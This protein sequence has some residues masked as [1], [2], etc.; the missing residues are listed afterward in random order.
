M[1]FY[2]AEEDVSSII[3]QEKVKGLEN[4][5]L[6]IIGASNR[7]ISLLHLQKE[8]FLLWNFHPYM[9]DFLHFI[10]HYRGPFSSEVEK[11]VLYP[12]Y[13]DDCW[14]YQKPP[15]NDELSGGYFKLTPQGIEKY[16]NLFQNAQKNERLSLLLTGIQVVRE[17][18]DKL[19]FEE[20]LLLIYDTY[21]EYKVRSNVSNGIFKKRKVLAQELYRKG[22]IDE[23]RMKSL[24]AG[25]NNG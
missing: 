1:G 12:F 17:L 18:Y 23:R 14:S 21:P 20:L 3:E 22:F 9:K 24:I 7:P 6:L 4:L 13:L 11:A 5:I 19:S 16:H 2:E 25:S 15:K 8:A 10:H